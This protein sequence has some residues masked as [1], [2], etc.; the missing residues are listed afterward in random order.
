MIIL[1][2][3]E[4]CTIINYITIRERGTLRPQPCQEISNFTNFIYDISPHPEGTELV[5]ALPEY[6]PNISNSHGLTIRIK[7]PSPR[8]NKVIRRQIVISNC[9]RCIRWYARCRNDSTL[10]IYEKIVRNNCDPNATYLSLQITPNGNILLH[11][12]HANKCTNTSE[13]FTDQLY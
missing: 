3:E 2:P 7:F 4:H 6:H 8:K 10:T 1:N 11:T 5:W 12:E 13:K 9:G